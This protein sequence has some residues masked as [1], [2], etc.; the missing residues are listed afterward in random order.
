VGDPAR[1]AP[2]LVVGRYAL[3]GEIASGGMASVHL[4]RLVGPAGFGRTVAVKRLHPHLARDP[5]FVAMF[6]DEARLAARIH[7]LNVVP[8]LDVEAT[9]GELFVVMEYVRGVSLMRLVRATKERGDR[10]PLPIA[11]AIIAGALHGLHAAHETTDEHGSPLGIIHRDVSPQNIL[12][13]VDG[14][15]RVLDFGVAKA[16]GRVQTTR[17]G[18]I[19]G[20]LAYMAPEQVRQDELT[21]TADLYAIAVVL[22][23]TITARRLFRGDNEAQVVAKVLAA[24]IAAPSTVRPDVSPELDAIVLK[25]LAREPADRYAT[26]QEMAIALERAVPPATPTDVGAWVKSLAASQIKALAD[27]V[28]EIE[29][30]A[31]ALGGRG[32]DR[33]FIAELAS[34]ASGAIGGAPPPTETLAHGS[35]VSRVVVT[36][37]T[38]HGR[39][40]SARTRMVLVLGGAVVLAVG[41]LVAARALTRP[42]APGAQ[43]VEAPALSVAPSASSSTQVLSGSAVAAQAP[44]PAQSHEGGAGTR[45]PAHP[46]RWLPPQPPSRAPANAP[47]ASTPAPPPAPT[48]APARTADCD[49]PYTIDA[50]GQKHYKPECF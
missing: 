27:R 38:S 19:K 23:E 17:E 42:S 9:Q 29:S 11:S 45:T 21:R 31:S 44:T 13:G 28:N 15:A 24:P 14:V 5:E 49:P 39:K 8:T 18:Q 50:A 46:G 26:G 22:W 4:A 41:A 43:I 16:A 20:K 3:H 37:A 25:G 47:S 10:V 32:D 7:H 33:R 40:R 2:P 34:G 35:Q 6:L 30:S 12:V 1:S 36:D 48:P